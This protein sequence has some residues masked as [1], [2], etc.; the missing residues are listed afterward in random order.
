MHEVR[1]TVTFRL[2]EDRFT[3]ECISDGLRKI[4]RLD[5]KISPR[6][7][8]KSINAHRYTNNGTRADPYTLVLL[9]HEWRWKA[10]RTRVIDCNIARHSLQ[11]IRLRRF[12]QNMEVD[13]HGWPAEADYYHCNVYGHIK[14]L[15]QTRLM[16]RDMGGRI[17][18]VL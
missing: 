3:T 14:S 13:E 9:G 11:G 16:L 17:R 6:F 4:L 7:Y 12:D 15:H 10:D 2:F 5:A 8:I 18:S 1:E